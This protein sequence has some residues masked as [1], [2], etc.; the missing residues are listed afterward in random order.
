LLRILACRS[1]NTITGPVTSGVRFVL[2]AATPTSANSLPAPER[3]PGCQQVTASGDIATFSRTG[4]DMTWGRPDD[5]SG[6]ASAT[7][8][9]V[10][11]L[12]VPALNPG[13][14]IDIAGESHYQD[15]L[16]Q[17]GGGRSAFGV[18]NQLITVELVREPANLHDPNAVKIQ[19]DGHH[20][21]YL[22]REDAPRFH[23]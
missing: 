9:L 14:A 22:P 10:S 18:R 11:W 19:A 7:S 15:A 20:L 17:V 8:A 3:N 5:R 21:G 1:V 16:E 4:D 23:A 6:V 2:C 13:P 12:Q